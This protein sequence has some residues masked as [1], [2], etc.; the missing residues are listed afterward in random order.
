MPHCRCGR[1]AP[2]SRRGAQL[3]RHDRAGADVSLDGDAAAESRARHDRRRR[4]RARVDG[5]G[6]RALAAIPAAR[7]AIEVGDGPGA[8]ES[9]GN[10]KA[11]GPL[12]VSAE[13]TANGLEASVNG[14]ASI[15]GRQTQR[16]F[17]NRRA[18][19]EC[20]AAA[21]RGG[22]IAALPV[23]YTSAWCSSGDTLN[24]EQGSRRRSARRSSPASSTLGLGRADARRR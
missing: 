13:T 9:Q 7:S 10:G 23:S 2:L 3:D 18:K 21:G 15:V 11:T 14:T 24:A 4:D 5:G 6:R 22:G 17:A 8:L 16:Q 1:G 12:T 20:R 19:G